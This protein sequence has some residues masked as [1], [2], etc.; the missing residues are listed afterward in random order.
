M[1][2][3]TTTDTR[4]AVLSDVNIE[5]NIIESQDNNSTAQ[6]NISWNSDEAATSQVE[7]GEGTGSS[8]SQ[9]TQEDKSLTLNHMVII[10]GLT[11]SKVYHLRVIS[12]DKSGNESKSVDYIT[13]TPKASD[14]ALDLVVSNL[15]RVFGG[16]M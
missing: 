12:K 9:K 4:P 13:I 1:V 11:P 3:T 16:I 5:A 10:N 2:F 15:Q 8:Y 14:N 6:L 7:Y